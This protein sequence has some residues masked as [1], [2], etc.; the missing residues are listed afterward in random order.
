M[1]G[2]PPLRRRAVATETALLADEA[3]TVAVADARAKADTVSGALLKVA[4]D[5]EA[6]A[7]ACMEEGSVGEQAW[8]AMR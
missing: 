2:I 6:A 1:P 3:V 8:H 4:V 5:T 7:A